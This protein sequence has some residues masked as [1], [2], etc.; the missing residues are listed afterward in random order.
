MYI[1]NIEITCTFIYIHTTGT[2]ITG[3]YYGAMTTWRTAVII[4][5]L[6]KN[7]SICGHTVKTIAC[8]IN[9]QTDSY[10]PP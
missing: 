4:Q 1:G 3:N 8:L 5:V 7:I 2:S 6:K 9:S 10:L